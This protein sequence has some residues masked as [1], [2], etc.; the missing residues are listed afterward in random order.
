MTPVLD[1]SASCCTGYACFTKEWSVSLARGSC[2]GDEGLS[3]DET[4][5]VSI[6]ETALVSIDSEARIWSEHIL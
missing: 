3:I 2:R 5:L 4:A 6:D 1:Q